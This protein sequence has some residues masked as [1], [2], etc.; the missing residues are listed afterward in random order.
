M[1]TVNYVR[2]PTARSHNHF[3]PFVVVVFKSITRYQTNESFSLVCVCVYVPKMNRIES[4]RIELN[5]SNERTNNSLIM[6][7]L[8]ICGTLM[9]HFNGWKKN[10][11]AKP[12]FSVVVV[13]G[14]RLEAISLI[15][16]HCEVFLPDT[17]LYL[18][19]NTCKKPRN[20]TL[21]FFLYIEW[22]YIDVHIIFFGFST[23]KPH[24]AWV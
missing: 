20:R 4:N 1:Y 2:C 22:Q 19:K 7:I 24:F 8:E 16:H 12:F 17:L 11:L 21:F 9:Y 14:M 10:M 23:K 13:V 6:K 5:W 18:Y 15:F 3:F